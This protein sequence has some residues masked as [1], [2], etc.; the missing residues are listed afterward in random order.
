MD[1]KKLDIIYGMIQNNYI[2]GVAVAID[3]IKPVGKNNVR[4]MKKM[5]ECIGITI[6]NTGNPSKTA[7]DEMHS[8]WMKRVEREDKKYVSAHFFVDDDSITQIIPIDE[9]AYHA[10]DGHGDG[11]YKTI[12]IEICENGDMKKAEEN[13][14]RLAASLIKTY[15]HLKI[16]KHQDWSGKY[17]PRALLMENRWESFKDSVL[18]AVNPVSEIEPYKLEGLDFLWNEKLITDKELWLKNIDNP[19]P[20]WAIGLILKRAV[21]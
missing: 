13:A 18:K 1:I 4:T 14:I 20:I 6:H 5:K 17:C 11:N 15:P 19:V 7:D 2:D 21:K 12:A 16:Y 8:N 10:G 9:V 3:I